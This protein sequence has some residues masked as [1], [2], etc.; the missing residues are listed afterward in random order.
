ME[1]KFQAKISDKK[2]MSINTTGEQKASRPLD[3]KFYAG[4]KMEEGMRRPPFD[5]PSFGATNIGKGFTEQDYGNIKAVYKDKGTAN[6]FR[7]Y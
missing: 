2:S 4:M 5:S 1:L 7:E 3:A 6:P